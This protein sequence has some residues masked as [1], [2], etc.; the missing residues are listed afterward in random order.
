MF[1][2]YDFRHTWKEIKHNNENEKE[3]IKS[4]TYTLRSIL[5][6]M[7][8]QHAMTMYKTSSRLKG[9]T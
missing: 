4:H 5:F 3:K 8:Q 9:E 1:Y 7:Y 6:E 2:I